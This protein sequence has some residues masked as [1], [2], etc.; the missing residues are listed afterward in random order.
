[1]TLTQHNHISKFRA[2]LWSTI[3]LLKVSQNKFKSLTELAENSEPSAHS[4]D[5]ES[6]EG[7]RAR[8]PRETKA[9]RVKVNRSSLKS[10][11]A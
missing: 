8:D 10:D 4:S 6:V 9:H 1:V 3:T 5:P 11:E 7:E 2:D